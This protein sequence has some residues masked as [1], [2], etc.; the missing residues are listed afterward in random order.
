MEINVVEEG[1]KK[2]VFEIEGEDHSLAN[3]L[4]N[5]LWNDSHVSV[6]GYTMEHPL[7]GKPRIVVETDGKNPRT[8]LVDAAKRLIKMNDKFKSLVL[9][10][11]K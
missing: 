5:E 2:I 10:V 1:K 11:V 7:V 3:S 9:K 4:V 6:S 8:A